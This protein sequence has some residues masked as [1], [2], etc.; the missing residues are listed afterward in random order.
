MQPRSI[1]AEIAASVG[2]R[3]EVRSVA[4]VGS[5]ARG[6]GDDSSDVDLLVV[7]DGS[8]AFDPPEPATRLFR[9]SRPD[10]A[11]EKWTF[12]STL[13]DIEVVSSGAIDRVVR[14][15]ADGTAQG[16][17]LLLASALHDAHLLT[18]DRLPTLCYG[19]A[20]AAAQARR[21]LDGMIGAATI[22]SLSHARGDAIGFAHR[23]SDL[24]IRVIGLLGAVNRILVPTDAPKWLP[25]WVERCPTRP[26][27]V[28]AILERA[29]REPCAE[30]A[31]AVDTMLVAVL[32]LVDEHVP[33]ASTAA[34]RYTLTLSP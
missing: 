23:Q 15:V 5:F 1:A 30:A 10:G 11:F 7:A 26:S 25:Y 14:G 19:D 8:F 2:A 6:L 27:G 24:S 20:L 28:L 9:L 12:G 29:I 13:V 16:H 32:D 33:D 17:D 21:H 34:A 22:L 4:L 18:G 3:H 31:A